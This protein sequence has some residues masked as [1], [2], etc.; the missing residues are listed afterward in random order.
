ML[1]R[2]EQL[3]DR[4]SG[5]CVSQVLGRDMQIDLRTGDLAVPEQI[6]DRDEPHACP[7]QVSGK[8]VS[9]TMG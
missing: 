9:Q 8:R 3:S 2:G 5:C 4:M 1:D 7:N 6:T